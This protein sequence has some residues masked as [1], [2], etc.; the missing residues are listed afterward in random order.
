MIYA[1]KIKMKSGYYSSQTLEEIDEIY[2]SGIGFCK[3]ADIHEYVKAHPNS[4]HVK[5][6]PYPALIPAISSR[7]ERYVRSNPDKYRHDDLLDLP[8][9]L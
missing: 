5:R 1:E 7:G 8:R 4:I 6:Y 9:V 3:K 2:L